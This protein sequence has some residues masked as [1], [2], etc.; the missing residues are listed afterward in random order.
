MKNLLKE[1][2]FKVKVIVRR[3]SNYRL[4]IVLDDLKILYCS[5]Y[6]CVISINFKFRK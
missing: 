6:Y 2:F 5:E 3:S 1:L 4:D